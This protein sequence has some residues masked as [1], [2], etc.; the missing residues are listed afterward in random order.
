M[1]LGSIAGQ[2]VGGTYNYHQHGVSAKGHRL[3]PSKLRQSLIIG[4]WH[5]SA[6]EN[7]RMIVFE[8][9]FRENAT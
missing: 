2:V 7:V 5:A 1:Y 3:S 6:T 4:K 8:W 9:K